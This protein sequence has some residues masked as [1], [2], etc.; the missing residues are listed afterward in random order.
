MNK[1]ENKLNNENE[2]IGYEEYEGYQEYSPD[3]LMGRISQES[4]KVS[5]I[6]DTSFYLD[7]LSGKFI[8]HR[9]INLSNFE[10]F[11]DNSFLSD[12]QITR[13]SLLGVTHDNIS[14]CVSFL[15]P[16]KLSREEENRVLKGPYATES[17]ITRINSNDFNCKYV[18]LYRSKQVRELIER[19]ANIN[20]RVDM[21]IDKESREN[22]DISQLDKFLSK[23]KHSVDNDT[24]PTVLPEHNMILD[25][26]NSDV[27]QQIFYTCLLKE[28]ELKNY[29]ELINEWLTAQKEWEKMQVEIN[30]ELEKENKETIFLDSLLPREK[31]IKE[32]QKALE[33]NKEI[34]DLSLE[35]D[36]DKFERLATVIYALM[37]SAEIKVLSK[38]VYPKSELVSPCRFIELSFDDKMYNMIIEYFNQTRSIKISEALSDDLLIKIKKF[39]GVNLNIQYRLT[40]EKYEK[41]TA[42]KVNNG[43]IIRLVSRT[44]P[45]LSKTQKDLYAETFFKLKKLL[46]ILGISED[47]NSFIARNFK[48][49]DMKRTFKSMNKM[50]SAVSIVNMFFEVIRNL[51]NNPLLDE[52]LS[53]HSSGSLLISSITSTINGQ[54]LVEIDGLFRIDEKKLQRMYPDFYYYIYKVFDTDMTIQE[55]FNLLLLNKDIV[56]TVF[57][58]DRSNPVQII[59]EKFNE[60]MLDINIA[61]KDK[62]EEIDLLE[63]P[64]VKYILDRLSI[65]V[66]TD[67]LLQ[68]LAGH[69]NKLAEFFKDLNSNKLVK[70]LFKLNEDLMK[71]YRKF[72]LFNPREEVEMKFEDHI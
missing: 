16:R 30:Q 17:R 24:E 62:E 53:K 65:F 67:L 9:T 12:I 23:A 72:G 56:Y 1:N 2:E 29:D 71:E 7:Y 61:K 57:N 46:P 49:K 55:F 3:E 21:L 39:I 26:G 20:V 36:E 27:D 70:G 37:T 15:K 4:N 64:L 35:N 63:I 34:I 54:P 51:N 10:F 31:N 47:T 5:K 19:A 58:F 44:A 42:Y 18:K 33:S 52:T 32:L 50:E 40:Y 13:M 28:D 45:E 60:S 59:M 68:H 66:D 38:D 8:Q 41:F 22:F 6:M 48:F 14:S 11:E 25:I 43:D 69:I